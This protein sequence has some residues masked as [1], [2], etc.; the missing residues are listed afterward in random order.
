M[1]RASPR[2]GTEGRDVIHTE[3]ILACLAEAEQ[4]HVY[5][6]DFQCAVGHR[7]RAV[8][9]PRQEENRSIH[10]LVGGYRN[11]AP[12]TRLSAIRS[13]TRSNSPNTAGSSSPTVTRCSRWLWA[14]SPPARG[15]TMCEGFVRTRGDRARHRPDDRCQLLVQPA[16]RANACRGVE[17]CN[18][19][20]F[21]E[22]IQQNDARALADFR[23]QTSIPVAAGQMEGTGGATESS[24]ST[25]R[26]T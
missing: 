6:C 19:L 25:M 17:D 7:R 9:Y 11:W 5:R 22:P 23:R 3:E 24:S 16:R 21:E 26:S 12:P 14:A 15:K 4:P 1:H 10:E 8:G 18:L 13:S 20:W 2:A